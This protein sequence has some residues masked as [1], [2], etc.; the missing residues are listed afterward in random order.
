[1][2]GDLHGAQNWSL[3]DDLHLADAEWTVVAPRQRPLREAAALATPAATIKAASAP[4]CNTPTKPAPGRS[5]PSKPAFTRGWETATSNVDSGTVRC[6]QLNPQHPA[7]YQAQ[8]F[9]LEEAQTMAVEKFRA[10]TLNARN[11]RSD[12]EHP[13]AKV[14]SQPPRNVWRPPSAGAHAMPAATTKVASAP[15]VDPKAD[16]D[17][18]NPL[19]PAYCTASWE[20]ERAMAV[21]AVRA[22]TPSARTKRSDPQHPSHYMVQG[23]SFEEAK[24]MAMAKH[25]ENVRR[26]ER[27]RF[28]NDSNSRNPQHPAYWMVQGLS[29][30][31]EAKAAA[32]A[33]M[34]ENMA[35]ARLRAADSR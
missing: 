26:A 15:R 10:N 9:A 29:S 28:S 21:E 35:G 20:V 8:G 14:H 34:K 1:M 19:H 12:P 16:S 2:Q 23:M 13:A 27:T 17:R 30:W 3:L 22:D 6:H 11:K 32:T 31:E 5:T 25:Q 4:A 24:G 33:R 18:S 7:F